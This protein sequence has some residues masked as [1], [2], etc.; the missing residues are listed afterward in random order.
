MLVADPYRSRK[1]NSGSLERVYNKINSLFVKR[2]QQADLATGRERHL[3]TGER[4]ERTKLDF[5]T[6]FVAV[7]LVNP[8]V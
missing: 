7:P 6:Q 3:T 2:Q 5:G 1:P 4:A 8:A